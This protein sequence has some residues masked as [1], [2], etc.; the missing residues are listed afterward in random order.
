MQEMSAS[1]SV[2]S[3]IDTAC[4][5]PLS[6]TQVLRLLLFWKGETI[7]FLEDP[8]VVEPVG[9]FSSK[10]ERKFFFPISSKAG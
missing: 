8:H 2:R 3:V 4:R 10:L 7:F 6:F 1:P 5:H 9:K